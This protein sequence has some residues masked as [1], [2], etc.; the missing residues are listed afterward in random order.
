MSNACEKRIQNVFLSLFIKVFMKDFYESLYYKCIFIF[1][2]KILQNNYPNLVVIF[3]NSILQ[4]LYLRVHLQWPY[5]YV[6]INFN[7]LCVLF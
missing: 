5:R 6:S 7:V 1:N 2:I 3:M 4:V